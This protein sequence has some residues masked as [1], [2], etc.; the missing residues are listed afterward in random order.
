MPIIPAIWLITAVLDRTAEQACSS[1]TIILQEWG[2]LAVGAED[3]LH[4]RLRQQLCAPSLI[5]SSPLICDEW[6]L[7]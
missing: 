5:A 4:N 3:L 2:G 6:L 1:I 7:I